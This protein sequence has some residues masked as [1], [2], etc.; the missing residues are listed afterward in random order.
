MAYCPKCGVEVDNSVSECP[1]CEFPIPD[2][3]G[4][5][6]V[7]LKKSNKYPEVKNIYSAY[8]EGVKNQVYF[9]VAVLLVSILLILTVIDSVFKVESSITNYFYLVTIALAAYIYFGLGF[10]RGSFNIIGITVTT[11]F[12][13]FFLNNI[14]GGDWFMTYALPLCI[15]AYLSSIAFHYMF[16]HSSRKNRF[17]Y[18]PT[19]VLL[20]VASL[21]IGVDAIVSWNLGGRVRLTWSFVAAMGCMC[22]VFILHFVINRIPDSTKET[23]RRKFHL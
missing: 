9:V 16:K 7:E 12:L 22:V 4:P 14:I 3:S 10:L 17:G 6:R 13:T 8:L 2:I 21:C 5:D 20:I 11:V 19:F 15:L 1:L 23:I 18:L